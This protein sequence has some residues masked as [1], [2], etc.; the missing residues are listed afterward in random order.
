MATLQRFAVH[1]YN[2][3]YI[4]TIIKHYFPAAVHDIIVQH[5]GLGKVHLQGILAC[6]WFPGMFIELNYRVDDS[7]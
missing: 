4:H 1:C 7:I 6:D 3:D 5:F 2:I